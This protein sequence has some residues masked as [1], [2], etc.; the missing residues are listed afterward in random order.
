L[1]SE[2]IKLIITEQNYFKTILNQKFKMKLSE[3]KKIQTIVPIKK[4]AQ[5]VIKGGGRDT[6]GGTGG[7]STL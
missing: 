3:I 2:A 7:V 5:V 6:R 1:C 4:E